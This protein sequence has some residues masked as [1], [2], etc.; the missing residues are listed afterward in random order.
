MEGGGWRRQAWWVNRGSL[1]ALGPE[2]QEGRDG[3]GMWARGRAPPQL[4]RGWRPEERLAHSQIRP[5]TVQPLS[6]PAHRRGYSSDTEQ[7]RIPA[8]FS[9][10]SNGGERTIS[11]TKETVSC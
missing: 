4:R 3:A 1:R 11:R 9:L 7:T 6:H 8:S 2:N 10:N 5:D